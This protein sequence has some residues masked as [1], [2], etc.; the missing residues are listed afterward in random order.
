MRPDDNALD[1]ARLFAGLEPLSGL[2]L[3]VSGGPDSL[4][5]MIL[6]A[7]WREN[8]SK[9]GAGPVSLS[10]ATVDH[11]LREDSSLEA[12]KVGEW[13]SSLGLPHAI[14]SWRGEKPTRAIQEKAR[15]A[16]YALLFA[17]AKVMGA[18]AVATGHHAD[19]Q[20]ETL[21]FR[22]ARGSGLA[23][24]A[25]M[26]R[27]QAFPG[28]RV[29]RPLLGLPKQA[30]VDFCRTQDQA[31]FDDPSNAHP[32]FARSRLRALAAPL[33][34]LGFGRAKAQKLAERARKGD[35]AIDWAAQEILRH[36]ALPE[37]N[38]YDLS[39]LEKAPRALFER[40]LSHALTC[41]AG[42]APQRLDRLES[43]AENMSTAMKTSQNFRAT[44]GGCVVVLNRNKRLALSRESPRKRG[45]KPES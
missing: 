3:A 27:D 19:D 28:G 40:F 34:D 18:E 26:A 11:E 33:H 8:S 36:S 10:V 38:V 17:H 20:W 29:I 4:A 22:L 37:K 16:R 14:L 15:E 13:A 35:A 1:P 12:A 45:F 44:L 31:F 39:S 9:G 30:L 23:G 25:G 6:A 7:Q 32:G 24:L 43:L 21:L 2:V 42:S 5:L 41:V